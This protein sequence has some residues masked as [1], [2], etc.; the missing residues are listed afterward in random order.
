[1]LPLKVLID[2]V[3]QIL[4]HISATSTINNLIFFNTFNEKLLHLEKNFDVE[5]GNQM[6]IMNL[7]SSN[8]IHVWIPGSVGIYLVSV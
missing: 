1:M 5:E 2:S 3:V 8:Q 4:V 6:H 7:K